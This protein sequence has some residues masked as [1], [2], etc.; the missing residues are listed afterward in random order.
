MT[1]LAPP[2][3]D[4]PAGD[5]GP[6]TQGQAPSRRFVLEA[7]L[8]VGAWCAGAAVFFGAQWSSGF[9]RIM[10]DPGDARLI[11]YLNEHWYLVL[12]HGQAWRSPPIF[13]PTQG[14]LGYADSFFLFQI[15]YAPFRAL[16]ADPFLALQLTVVALSL[17]AFACFVV[18]V[19]VVFRAPLVVAIAGALVFTFATNLSAHA[20][21]FQLFGIYFVPPIALLA[22]LSW[23]SREARPLHSAA[24]AALVGLLWGLFIFS[25]YYAAWFSTLAV[26]IVVVLV[27]LLA[28]R[29]AWSELRAA[30]R[31]AWRSLLALVVGAAVGIIPFLVTYLPV[32]H[33]EGTRQY[34]DAI[35]YAVT[36]HDADNL[37][38]GNLVWAHLLHYTWA[39]PSPSNYEFSY[40]ISPILFLSVV[41]GGVVLAWAAATRRLHVTLLLRLT[42]ALCATTVILAVLPIKSR[43]GSAWAVVWHIPGAT[44]IRA[45][46]RIG[47]ASDL[48]AAVALVLLATVAW[49]SWGRLRHSLPLLVAAL[50]LL[51]VIVAEQAH[52]SSATALQRNAQLSALS[53]VPPAPDGCT[54]FFVINPGPTATPDY[55][56]QT[57]AMLISQRL[58]LPTLNGYSGEVPPHWVLSDP[59]ASTYLTAVEQWERAN[60]L[61]TGVCSLDLATNSW[62]RHPTP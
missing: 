53:A 5:P 55:A 51:C 27:C 7:L 12:T 10:G 40:A 52:D 38:A 9:N 62:H 29:A 19:R 48:V 3:V 32:A 2:E 30:L 35:A 1:L 34:S 36:W 25:T 54:T 20:G 39:T 26:A 24:L 4:P 42:L 17:M 56:L 43:F 16:G 8:V 45:I 50:V 33:Q 58:G 46:D 13:T 21:S 59:T 57:S 61:T 60:G 37:G 41:A 47:V 49:R 14:V 23:R 22:A 18:F 31:T 28:P 15:F 11:V 44:A 6:G